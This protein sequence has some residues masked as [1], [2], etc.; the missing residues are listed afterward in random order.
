MS[1]FLTKLTGADTKGELLQALVEDVLKDDGSF[2]GVQ[3]QR[4]GS[5]F[6]FDLKAYRKEDGKK[7][8]WKIECKNLK[9]GTSVVDISPKLVWHAGSDA[10]DTFVIV[11]PYGISNE[12]QKL[13][14]DHKFAFDIEVWSA[15]YLEELVYNS[16][17]ARQRL[18]LGGGASVKITEPERY[19][20]GKVFIDVYDPYG[21]VPF[22]YDYFLDEAGVCKA[23][24]EK[25][26]RACANVTNRTNERF[27]I[28]QIIVRTVK[29]M[30]C[31]FRVLRQF[32][33]KGQ[34]TP[35][36]L[37]FELKDYDLGEYE[38][39]QDSVYTLDAGATEY[40]DFRLAANQPPGYYQFV[41]EFFGRVGGK[42]ISVT[43]GVFPL[44][45]SSER[46]DRATL[47]VVG[48]YYD[49]P[50]QTILELSEDSWDVLK[51]VRQPFT[52][53]GP[54]MFDWS[55]SDET[56]K[57]YDATDGQKKVVLDLGI[58]I[59][60]ELFSAEEFM[61]SMMS[62]AKHKGKP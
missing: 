24:T 59:E 29:F 15:D 21:R 30:P 58:P 35:L 53:L 32:K 36:K 25:Y 51:S 14:E 1:E 47:C 45:V 46:Q 33:F 34:E 55:N 50:V 17:R 2:Y 26:F 28:N 57:I 7:T 3:Q 49:T 44:I 13:L 43:S 54:T 16:P 52:F 11:S 4:N 31:D 8:C 38:I 5:Q 62:S 41:F 6:G 56:W 23:Y 12:L 22:A 18:G 19:P 20:A 9:R 42:D 48:R 39:F 60:E 61:R 10:L 40:I 37:C 27:V